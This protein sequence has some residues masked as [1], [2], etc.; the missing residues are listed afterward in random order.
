M[1][2]L[3]WA[4]CSRNLLRLRPAAIGV[5]ITG[6][7]KNQA[8]FP[9][10]SAITF[11][12]KLPSFRPKPTRDVSCILWQLAAPRV[13]A[14]TTTSLAE[15]RM[16]SSAVRKL[17]ATCAV[18]GLAVV[19]VASAPKS[20]SAWWR[21]YGYGYGYGYGVGVYVPPVVVAPPAYYAP[22]PVYYAPPARAWIPAHWENGY[23][24][25][26]HWS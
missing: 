10:T 24:V 5:R 26:G 11:P 22:P 2:G 21:P 25:P 4:T 3:V 9:E 6:R 18:L 12:A 15:T 20:A 23:W 7:R 8:I 16:T 17:T 1:A 14:S 19:G 13:R